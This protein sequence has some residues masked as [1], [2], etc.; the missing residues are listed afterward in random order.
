[1]KAT[2]QAQ[3]RQFTVTEGDVVFLNR[4]QDSNSGDTITI[5]EVL[6]V[7]EGMNAR[8]GTPFVDGATVQA[9]ILEN[10]RGKKVHIWKRKR[11]KGYKRRQGHR[12]E[13]TVLKIESI[14]A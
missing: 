7:G 12:Q 14:T 4:Y 6:M 3:G 2:I 8:F 10:K 11:R 5:K 1:M 13:L 9:K